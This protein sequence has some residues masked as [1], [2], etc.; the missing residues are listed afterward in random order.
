MTTA[1]Y[2]SKSILIE[3]K[4][5]H[6]I[7]WQEKV[8]LIH[9]LI[10][11]CALY[12]DTSVY[13]LL[14]TSVDDADQELR[15]LFERRPLSPDIEPAIND[16]EKPPRNSLLLLFID[17]A[18]STSIGPLLNGWRSALSEAPGT[19]LVI[20]SA[21]FTKFQRNAPDLAS[22]I[23]PKVLDTSIML[24]VWNSKTSEK[25]KTRIPDAIERVLR[26]LPG[27][28]PSEQEIIEWIKA[29]PPLDG[30]EVLKNDRT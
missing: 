25:M 11:F 5:V 12:S 17:Q 20:R 18:V 21:D 2:F 27:D 22:S 4:G 9:A 1:E 28:D 19:L 29:H 6:L 30:D 24:S 26:K 15:S 16:D 7:V 14:L 23:G 10:V 3:G 13:P 8:D